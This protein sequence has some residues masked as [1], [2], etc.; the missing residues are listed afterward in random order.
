MSKFF[1]AG[2]VGVTKTALAVFSTELGPGKPLNRS[3]VPTDT[4]STFEDLI[5]DYKATLD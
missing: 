5:T 4:H 2:D 1:L 3:T